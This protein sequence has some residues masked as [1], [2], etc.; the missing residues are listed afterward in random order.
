MFEILSDFNLQSRWN[1]AA[2]FFLVFTTTLESAV[3]SSTMAPYMDSLGIEA[4][5]YNTAFCAAFITATLLQ[6]SIAYQKNPNIRHIAI[7][8]SVIAIVGNS[9]YILARSPQLI[10]LARLL[11]GFSL[12]DIC[13][14]FIYVQQ[15]IPVSQRKATIAILLVDVAFGAIIGA[16]IILSTSKMSEFAGI[17]K[18]NAPVLVM[19]VFLLLQAIIFYFKFNPGETINRGNENNTEYTP[20]FLMKFL[21]ATLLNACVVG[22]SRTIFEQSMQQILHAFHFEYVVTTNFQIV[23]LAAAVCGIIFLNSNS[24]QSTS[25][26]IT[27]AY[28]ALTITTLPLM[29]LNE[30]RWYWYFICLSVMGLI[31]GALKVNTSDKVIEICNQ[32]SQPIPLLVLMEISELTVSGII[33]FGCG[34]AYVTGQAYGNEMW[35]WIFGMLVTL[36]LTS[37]SMLVLEAPQPAKGV[38]ENNI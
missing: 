4:G 18:L 26:F 3:I 16:L 14:K 31:F 35:M 20:R 8:T 28:I 27:G 13:L 12:G 19:N 24:S 11:T 7:V 1:L 23:V 30:S 21:F 25:P 37:I 34:R 29:F 6:I 22:L 38:D 9:I 33:C 15:Y 36:S 10:V 5:W 17:T 2:I 32:H